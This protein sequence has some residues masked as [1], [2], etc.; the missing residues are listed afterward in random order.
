M[1]ELMTT[2]F[3]SSS[4]LR[5]IKQT[6]FVLIDVEDS[7]YP[8]ITGTY[9]LDLEKNITLKEQ[10]NNDY[11]VIVNHIFDNIENGYPI[12]H[13]LTGKLGKV[14]QPRPKTGKKDTYTWAFYLKKPVL[15]NILI[16]DKI[17]TELKSITCQEHPNKV[18]THKLKK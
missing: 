17:Q 7:S 11:D 8:F 2:N 1:N 16:G 18:N 12:D 3:S 14:M 5:K 9:Y 13:N 6:L 15:N 4:L 10:M